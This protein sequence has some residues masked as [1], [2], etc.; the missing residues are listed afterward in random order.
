VH[1]WHLLDLVSVS[2]SAS[3]GVVRGSMYRI[4]GTLVASLMQEALIR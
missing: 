3:R 1:E 2:N 4:D